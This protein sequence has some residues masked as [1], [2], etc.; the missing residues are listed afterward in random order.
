[1]WA[2][3]ASEASR[4]IAASVETSSGRASLITGVALD[5]LEHARPGVLGRAG[6]LVPLAVEEAVRR[7]LVD[8]Q[9]VLDAR[10]GERSLEGLVVLG[11]DV[12]VGTG[13]QREQRCLD[14]RGELLRAREPSALSPGRP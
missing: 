1:M 11:G 9:L 4:W 13:L 7:A 14:L 10:V 2:R 6:E 3:A 12:L 8:D 5:E